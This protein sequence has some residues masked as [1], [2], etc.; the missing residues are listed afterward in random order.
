MSLLGCE[1]EEDLS[2]FVSE[3]KV[4]FTFFGCE[5]ELDLT[6]FS[7][8]GEIDWIEFDCVVVDFVI[9]GCEVGVGI[10]ALEW[11]ALEDVFK[12]SSYSL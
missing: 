10:L 4:D 3:N 7:C 1:N 2:F 12:L 5:N 8:E 11:V 6:P 9:L